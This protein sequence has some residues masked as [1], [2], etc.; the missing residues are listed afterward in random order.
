MATTRIIECIGATDEDMAHLRLLLRIA[1]MDLTDSWS[2]GREARADIVIVDAGNLIGNSALRRTLQRGIDCAQLI[3]ADAPAPDGRYLRKPLRREALVAL[4][5]GLARSAIAPMTIMAQGDN[6]FDMD[7][8]ES[9]EVDGLPVLDLALKR[10][11]AERDLDDFEAIFKRDPL[12]DT[13]QFLIP[14]KLSL[15]AGV[16]Y[17]G[18]ATARSATR[19]S[20][21]DPYPTAGLSADRIGSDFH[22][23]GQVDNIEAHPMSAYLS[24][25]LLG[26]PARIALPGAPALVLDPKGQVFHAQG[27]LRTLEIYCREPLRL[28]AWERL[29][30]SEL[31]ALRDRVPA[32]PYLRLQWLAS[33]LA[34]GGYLAKHLDPG[35]S[36]RLIKWLELAQDYPRAFRVGSNMIAPQNL[37]EIAHASDVSMAEVFDVVNAYD[38]IGYLEWTRRELK[39]W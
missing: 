8:G 33:F 17:V 25:R 34:S 21:S 3:E 22:Y 39:H 14:E 36:Y 6:F 29:V 27:K 1:A 11:D 23:E 31:H 18:D 20:D 4:L 32:R 13:S 37:A 26:G 19:A 16:A 10:S 28:D 7:L 9:D 24:G 35:G 12:A 38:A 30:S 5:N 2:W 15:D